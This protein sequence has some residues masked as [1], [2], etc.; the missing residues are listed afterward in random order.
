MT[1]FDLI[2]KYP[3]GSLLALLLIIGGLNQVASNFKR[4]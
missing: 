1:L 3:E 4:K 2:D